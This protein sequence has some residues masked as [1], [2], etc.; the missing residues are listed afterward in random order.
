MR[1]VHQHNIQRMKIYHNH[2]KL[3]RVLKAILE[4]LQV[5]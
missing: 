4:L 3:L 1:F 5:E 2:I